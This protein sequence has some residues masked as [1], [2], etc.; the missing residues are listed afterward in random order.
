MQEQNLPAHTPNGPGCALG[1]Q[2]GTV[3]GGLAQGC[4]DPEPQP[5]AD[6]ARGVSDQ[7]AAPSRL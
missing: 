3:L 6:P 2:M 5:L 4:R 1:P 7:P